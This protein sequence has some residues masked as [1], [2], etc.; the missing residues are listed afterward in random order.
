MPPTPSQSQASHT[1]DNH[2]TISRVSESRTSVQRHRAAE[3]VD[4]A[5]N[6]RLERQRPFPKTCFSDRGI[7]E[8]RGAAAGELLGFLENVAQRRRAIHG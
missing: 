4:V 2:R 7:D 1:G 8:N 5:R 3:A 6:H